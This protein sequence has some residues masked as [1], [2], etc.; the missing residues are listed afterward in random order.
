MAQTKSIVD[1]LLSGVSNAHIPEGYI[2]ENVLPQKAVKQR[3]GIIGAIGDNHLRIVNSKMAGRG[4]ARRFESIVREVDNTYLI[5]KH[6]L[7]GVVSED[8]YDNIYEPFDAESEEVIG[9][10]S[11]I[12]LEKEKALADALTSTSILTQNQTLAG[13]SQFSDYDSS[14]PLGVFKTAQNAILD[15]SGMMPNKAIV[16]QKVFN[17][18]KYHPQILGT[19]GFADNRAGTLSVAEVASAIGVDQLYVGKVSYNSAKLGQSDSLAQVWGKDMIL[20]Y[21]PDSPSK[22]QKTLGYY[23]VM[24]GRG[25]RRVYKYAIDNPPNSTGVIVQDDYSFELVDVKCAYLIKDAIA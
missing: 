2:S 13:T 3:T 18:L 9:L 17:T 1:K 12:W 8:D 20:Y 14:D 23:M 21:A 19:L 16:S 4:K 6:G 11:V 5:D 15:G 25:P 10:T 24:E 22:Y 7:E